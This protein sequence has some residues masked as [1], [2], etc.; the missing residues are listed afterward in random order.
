MLSLKL[1]FKVVVLSLAS[2]GALAACSDSTKPNASGSAGKSGDGGA[3]N[4]GTSSGGTVSGGSDDGQTGG[5]SAG[6]GGVQTGGGGA[7]A[8]GKAGNPGAAGEGGFASSG[9]G[10]GGADT[11]GAGMGGI[12]EGGAAGEGQAGQGGSAT[13]VECGNGVKEPGEE[14]EPKATSTCSEQCALVSTPACAACEQAGACV[15]LSNICVDAFANQDETSICYSVLQCVRDSNCADGVAP[16]AS[17]FCGSLTTQACSAA[18]NSGAGAPAGACAAVIRE[19]M[20]EGVDVATN[21]EVLTRLIDQSF[22]GGAAL[23]R[24][25]CDKVDPNCI[26]TCGYGN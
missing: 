17:C 23:A 22:P 13:Q 15:D 20:S 5:T 21:S 19:A 18:P 4:A 12:G 14:C 16:L 8:G 26:D 2:V 6:K 7:A 11:G 1:S 10:M 25:N 3:S 9:A 24:V